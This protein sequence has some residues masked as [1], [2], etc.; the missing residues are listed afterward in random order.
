MSRRPN[1]FIGSATWS[2]DGTLIACGSLTSGDH[3]EIVT[4]RVADGAIT[5]IPVSQ[6]GEI[7]QVAWR[8]DGRSLLMIVEKE[9]NILFQIWSVNYPDGAMHKVTDDS[10]NYSN[11]SLSA[12]GN[13]IVA[14]QAAQET[15]LWL[16]AAGEDASRAK[17][18]TH[19]VDKYD[20]FFAIN[21]T[22][23][24]RIIYENAPSGR[25]A[26]WVMDS[27]GHRAKE[28]LSPSITTAA[29]SDGNFLVYQGRDANGTG[30]F[31]FDVKEGEKQRLTTGADIY[32]T[33]SPDGQTVVF[34][35]FANDVAIWKVPL[36]GGEGS[37]LTDL[38]GF[39]SAPAISPDGRFIAFLRTGGGK[40][41]LEALTI[42]GIEGGEI[43]REFDVPVEQTLNLGKRA[44][45]WTPDSQG[46]NFVSVK[47]N[48][49]NIWRQRLDASPPIQITNYESGRIFNFA[50]SPDG[51]QLAISRG[52]FNR[53]VVLI[54]DIN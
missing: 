23:D 20:G 5:A 51:R 28:L 38:P 18:L 15:H 16:L 37:K 31:R 42:T 25:S 34:L 11:I 41:P 32:P 9:D 47:K 10:Q 14:V 17:Q 35:R 36:E 3:Q 8:A 45:Q 19:G 39:L 13:S 2:P 43:V 40:M 49:S 48:V 1:L 26:V 22:D 50:F 30:L 53:D 33:I 21:W 4:A 52:T 46:I 24:G 54:N 27:D 6:T 44:L 12:D 29:S 7:L